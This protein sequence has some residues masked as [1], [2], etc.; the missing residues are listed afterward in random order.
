MPALTEEQWEASACLKKSKDQFGSNIHH[1]L[2]VSCYKRVDDPSVIEPCRGA[3][4]PPCPSM[5]EGEP[6]IQQAQQDF[7]SVVKT[8]KHCTDDDVDS[9]LDLLNSSISRCWR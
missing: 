2:C 1:R 7:W 3:P 6:T 9:A 8:T 5:K 4:H